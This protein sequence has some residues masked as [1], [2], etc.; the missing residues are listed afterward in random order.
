MVIHRTYSIS[1]FSFLQYEQ[2]NAGNISAIAHICPAHKGQLFSRLLISRG[3]PGVRLLVRE[4]KKQCK[5]CWKCALLA[6]IFFMD[7]P[8]SWTV[9]PWNVSSTSCCS[10]CLLCRKHT[11]K[12][13]TDILRNVTIYLSFSN[14]VA[15]SWETFSDISNYFT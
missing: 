1:R 13:N 6:Y 8:L 11:L 14:S 2:Q 7:V 3:P 9:N 15:G 10:S 4:Y 12:E 5:N